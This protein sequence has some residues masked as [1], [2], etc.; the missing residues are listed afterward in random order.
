MTEIPVS[1]VVV[2]RNRPQALIRCLTGISQL[3]YAPFEVVVVADT[4]G[5][6]AVRRWPPGTDLK[7]VAFNAPNIAAARNLGIAAAAGQVVAFLDDGAV[8]E[9]SWLAHLTVAFRD[10][11]VGIA[12]GYVRGRD[13]I[14]WQSRAQSVDLAG[15]ARDLRITGDR[16]VV[17]TPSPGRAI[18]TDAANMAIRRRVIARIGGF[19]PNLH[20][21]L[22]DR[23]VNLRLAA[24]S[25]ATAIVPLA[26]VH[27]GDGSHGPDRPPRDLT[28]L[29]ASWAVFLGKHCPE[30]NA[31]DI[32]QGIQASERRRLLR[33]MVAG[34]LEPR[35]VRRL[36]A[37]L[38][39]GYGLGHERQ[40]LD[41]API[42]AAR[43]P[44][45]RYPANP[46][47]PG[48]T[49]SGRLW[50][51]ARLR[52]R[53]EENAAAGRVPSVYLFSPTAARHRVSYNAGGFWEH[54]G[55]LFGKSLP[56]DPGFRLWRFRTRVAR[57]VRLW[58]AYR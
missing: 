40:P 52:R 19:D 5:L 55:G 48:I 25:V 37:G 4:S 23:D 16:P 49:L 51:A 31:A 14:S 12:G 10:P 9:P 3:R 54:R 7:T 22:D 57:E 21:F 30:L 41:M 45:R 44:F 42:Q 18:K 35:D 13:G 33:H 17:L 27:R 29:G 50:S 26:V 36:M 47:R 1:I 56:A 15:Q 32:W 28:Q 11:N 53:A 38:R 8:P 6:D 2:S 20:A 46:D 43:D 24:H 58:T 34:E 39:H